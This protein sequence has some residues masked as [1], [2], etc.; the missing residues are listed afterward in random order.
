MATSTIQSKQLT[1]EIA[2]AIIDLGVTVVESRRGDAF[3]LVADAKTITP[4]AVVGLLKKLKA[5]GYDSNEI[6]VTFGN[7]PSLLR[8]E[9][10]GCGCGGSCSCG[11]GGDCGCSR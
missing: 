9:E 3:T 8:V 10:S 5:N 11:E 2:K 6:W 7:Q 1:P 4:E